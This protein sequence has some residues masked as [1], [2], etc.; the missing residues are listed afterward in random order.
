MA[1]HTRRR[2]R[3]H[4]RGCDGDRD[5]ITPAGDHHGICSCQYMKQ[6]CSQLLMLT[7]RNAANLGAARDV[8]SGSGKPSGRCCTRAN[9][10]GLDCGCWRDL[11]CY[12]CGGGV[13]VVVDHMPRGEAGQRHQAGS[14][15]LLGGHNADWLSLRSG[16]MERLAMVQLEI[17]AGH[18]EFINDMISGP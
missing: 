9:G 14:G 5:T 3:A 6:A 17:H 1:L 12:C 16:R 10:R 13:T 8:A 11:G 18:R 4:G 15:N 7:V 2:L